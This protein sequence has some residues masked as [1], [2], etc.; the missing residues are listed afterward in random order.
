MSYYNTYVRRTTNGEGSLLSV[1]TD[2]IIKEARK[3]LET[4]F[5]LRAPSIRFK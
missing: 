4:L 3:K 5:G 1:K 2:E